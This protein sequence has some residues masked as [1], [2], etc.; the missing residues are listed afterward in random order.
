MRYKVGDKVVIKKDIKFDGVDYSNQV[1]TIIGIRKWEHLS[2]DYKVD[3]KARWC[4]EDEMIDHEATAKLN[5]VKPIDLLESW[6]IVEF[7]NKQR[8]F[9][10]KGDFSTML[11]D[12]QKIMFVNEYNFLIMEGYDDSLLNSVNHG[13][14]IMRIYKPFVR[15]FKYMLEEDNAFKVWERKPEPKTIKMTLTEVAT[16]PGLLS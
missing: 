3:L 1:A 15:G 4:V 9:V 11:Y 10:I 14:D 2:D 7:R 6:F 12:C 8:M 16:K 13:Y 5:E